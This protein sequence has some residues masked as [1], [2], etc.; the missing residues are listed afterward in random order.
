M[1]TE[2]WALVSGRCVN[3]T[4]S[5]TDPIAI[6]TNIGV[7]ENQFSFTMT[8]GVC[9]DTDYM[10]ITRDSL[11]IAN[12]GPDMEICDDYATAI[13]AEKRRRRNRTWS[14]PDKVTDNWNQ[15]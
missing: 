13:I 15:A 4:S 2:L 1:I 9:V 3:N 6:I 10:T 14:T 5:L 8:N 7:R 11:V 12:A